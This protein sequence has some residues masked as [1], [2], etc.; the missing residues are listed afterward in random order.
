[1]PKSFHVRLFH[2]KKCLQ[3]QTF[4][5]LAIG[6]ISES[7]VSPVKEQLDALKDGT[8]SSNQRLREMEVSLPFFGG[9]KRQ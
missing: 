5:T 4:Q 7:I 3:S 1:M 8:M 9:D 2:L 6:I